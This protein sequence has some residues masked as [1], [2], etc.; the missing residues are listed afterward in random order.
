MM[1]EALRKFAEYME[2][3]LVANDHKGGWSRCNRAQLLDKLHEEVSE[4]DQVIR[5]G[6]SPRDIAR[7]AADVANISMMIADNWG[8]YRG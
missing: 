1:R 8:N 3:V 2:T 5:K 6:V 7:E 4:L